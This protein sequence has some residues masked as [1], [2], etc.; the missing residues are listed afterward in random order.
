MKITS[1][2]EITNAEAAKI[3]ADKMKKRELTFEQ[4]SAYDF[5]K[6]TT[7]TTMTNAKKLVEE[8]A[9]F[10]LSEEVVATIANVLP[11]DD[12][13]LK[14]IVKGERELKKDET[15]KI[16]DIVKKYL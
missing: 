1:K 6:N 8:L 2:T 5:L 16:L 7:K 12:V 14:L 15:T 10:S 3:L 9:E 4:Q 13:T 11:T